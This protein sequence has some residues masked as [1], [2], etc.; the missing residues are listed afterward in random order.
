VTLALLLG[1][2][3]SKWA[4]GLP[5]ASELFDFDL[6]IWG[7][8]DARKFET[9]RSC[10]ESWDATHPAGLP[11]Q[12]IAD[13][14][15][16]AGRQREAI[17]WYLTR[18][19]S[20]P[21]IWSEWHAGRW[22]RHVLMIDENRRFQIDGVV[23]ARDFLQRFCGPGLAGII[24]TNYD[25][26]VEY[27][28]G[29]RGFNYGTVG[30]VLIG[31]GAYPV[32]QWLH[33]V[34]LMG[35]V[36]LAKIHGSTSWDEKGHYTDGRRGL[37]GGALIV[38][39]TPD[40]S[41]PNRLEAV[42]SLAEDMLERSSALLVFGFGF[43]KYDEAV[44]SILRGSGRRLTAVLLIDIDPKTER[45]RRLWPGATVLSS[46]PPPAGDRAI[47]DWSRCVKAAIR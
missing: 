28:L 15:S 41:R 9:A 32:S 27:A 11:E 21:F 33:P 34:R 46:M 38:A 5:V 47:R 10:K 45:A 30:E 14:L 12:F 31:R 3:F 35:R 23:R 24:T 40:K 26:L 20:E 2:G 25:M 43:N 29:T 22:R 17:L 13:A 1:A 8:R 7:P 16:F 42:W 37:T 4:A 19:L 36:P 6:E 44:L 39:P 18:R